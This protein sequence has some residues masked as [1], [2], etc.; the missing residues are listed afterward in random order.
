MWTSDGAS[1]LYNAGDES[2]RIVMFREGSEAGVPTCG[3]PGAP[4]FNSQPAPCNIRGCAQSG[5]CMHA[6]SGTGSGGGGAL[7]AAGAKADHWKI[8]WIGVQA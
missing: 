7:T 3:D 8:N 2:F 4:L 5:G 1:S 6:T